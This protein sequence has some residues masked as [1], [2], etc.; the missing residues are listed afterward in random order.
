MN[1]NNELWG[2]QIYLIIL[3]AVVALMYFYF[4][5]KVIAEGYKRDL[6]GIGLIMVAILGSPF[7]AY[8]FVKATKKD[9]SRIKV[10]Y[11]NADGSTSVYSLAYC[12]NA[13]I[14]ISTF[15]SLTDINKICRFCGN[16]FTANVNSCEKC[17]KKRLW[18]YIAV[19]NNVTNEEKIIELNKWKTLTD[20]DII[21]D[22]KRLKHP[23]KTID[24]Q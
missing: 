9:T 5:Y 4:F 24:Y 15:K 8:A 18:F 21:K 3:I 6:L 16:I 23:I 17:N 19:K 10:D 11:E 13:K 12:I 20:D 7:M 2:L 22:I 14:K 1:T